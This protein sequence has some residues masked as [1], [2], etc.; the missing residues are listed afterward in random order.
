MPS[1]SL[2]KLE[3]FIDAFFLG[4]GRSKKFLRHR[5]PYAS[6]CFI[7]LNGFDTTTT[8][9]IPTTQSLGGPKLVNGAILCRVEAFYQA[10][11]N[12]LGSESASSA[13]CSTVMLTPGECSRTLKAQPKDSS[14][15]VS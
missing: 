10:I 5:S 4:I 8:N 13:I 11:R 2:S 1:Q 6:E 3:S 15:P 14:R 9:V 12:S 7:A